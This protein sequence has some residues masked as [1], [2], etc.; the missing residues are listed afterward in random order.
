MD[1][2]ELISGLSQPSAFPDPVGDVEV[3]QTHISIVFLAGNVAYKV[4]KPVKLSFLDF[5]TLELRKSVCDQEVRL[6]RRLAPD[7]Y[8]GVVPVTGNDTEL[9]FEG[10][11]A[12]VEWA[13][14]MRRLPQEATLEHLVEHGDINDLQVAS[15][16]R[17]LAQFHASAETSERIASFGRFDAVARNVRENFEVAAPMVGR[18]I[19]PAVRDRLVGLTE[20]ALA[21]Q[22]ELIEARAARGMPRDT[23]GDLHLDHVYLFPEQSP[24]RDLVIVDCIEFNERFRYTDPVADMAF[25]TMDLQFHGRWDLARVFSDSYF[26]ASNDAEGTRLL[27]LYLSYRAAVRGKVDGLQLN[28]PEIPEAARAAA[29]SR[30][31]G[32]WLLALGSLERPAMR[33]CLLLAAGLPGTGKSTLAR[34]LAERAGLHVIRSDVVRKELA[35]ISAESGAQA[36]TGQGIYT[37]EWNA[38][39]YAECLARAEKLLFA[40]Q[41]VLIDANFPDNARRRTFLREAVAWGVPPLMFV[42]QADPQ[43]VHERLAART[44]DASDADWSVYQSAAARWEDPDNDVR[45]STHML[46]T[47]GNVDDSTNQAIA[48]LRDA[49]LVE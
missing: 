45:R 40:G 49:G 35:G 38:R 48:V 17:R 31:C 7:V 47:T 24:P 37:P 6:N 28:E 16:A 11:G 44:A 2:S 27:P 22:Q 8:L 25:L 42:C 21:E 12:A 15:L 43:V 20:A 41:R 14:K 4:K 36:P 13:V 10:A 5:S 33:P 34:R 3:L 18:T 29:L 46:D 30:G 23:H 39:T 1:V 19:S 26:A 32:H 9:K